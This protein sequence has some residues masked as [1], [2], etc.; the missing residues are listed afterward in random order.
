MDNVVRA[1]AAVAAALP[2]ADG[3]ESEMD[4]GVD[5]GECEGETVGGNL[6]CVF[7]MIMSLGEHASYV[8]LTL[9]YFKLRLQVAATRAVFRSRLEH[10]LLDK[11]GGLALLSGR[12]C[13][14]AV[15]VGSGD[16]AAKGL[17]MD[18]LAG[19][20]EEAMAGPFPTVTVPP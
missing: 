17:T 18:R 3:G 19:A 16:E 1:V 14:V 11:P 12:L 6:M 8:C 20:L 7:C 15:G 13:A 9:Y 10:G 5:T 2:Q 4:D